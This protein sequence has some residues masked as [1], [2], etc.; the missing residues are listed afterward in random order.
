MA[1]V[2]VHVDIS[3][4]A[5]AAGG[6]YQVTTLVSLASEHPLA[7]VNVSVATNEPEGVEGVNIASAGSAF[8]VHAPD[9]PPPLQ[10]G[11]PLYVPLA[12]APVIG[13]AAVAVQVDMSEPASA[14]GCVPHVICLVS[15]S[16]EQPLAPVRVNVAVNVPDAAAGV[17]EARAGSAF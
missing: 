11:V 6:S 13:I 2:P 16:S 4:P 12:V 10:V 9:P 14:T 15:V 3:E 17:N 5:L 1:A 7:P 8:C